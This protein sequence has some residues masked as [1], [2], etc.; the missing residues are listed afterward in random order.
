MKFPNMLY[1]KVLRA[2]IPHAMIE[3]IDTT[4]A[5]AMEGVACVLTSN[6]IPGKNLF[7]IAFQDQWALA[8][9]KVRYIG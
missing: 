5:Q 1:G 9:K 6:D 7:G 2:G 4:V 8:E 3:S